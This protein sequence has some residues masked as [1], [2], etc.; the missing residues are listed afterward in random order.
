MS[1][2]EKVIETTPETVEEAPVV[3][4][5]PAAE[6]E[7]AAAN[8][9]TTDEVQAPEAAAAEVSGT[10]A[11]KPKADAARKPARKPRKPVDPAVWDELKAMQESGEILT[12]KINAAV[13]AGV[14]S[15][16][17]GIRGFIPASLLSVKY[18][19]DLTEWVNKT[20][21][22]KVITVEQENKRLVLSGKAVEQERAAAEKAA[23][24]AAVQIG[25]IYD[26]KVERIT[27][28]GAFVGFGDGL[29]GLVH[30]SQ[31]ANHRIETP[32][33]VVKV[34]DTVKVK[35]IG[36]KDG[37]LSLSMKQAVSRDAG[38]A[39]AKERSDRDSSFSY[40]EEGKATTGLAS[41]LANIKID[42]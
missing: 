30:I 28:F 13:N 20:I 34:G 37:K 38:S 17:K 15:Y 24:I 29:S 31:M 16:V 36:N 42:E 21:D 6:P 25:D 32:N 5:A 1:T 35:V 12:V 18:V 22:V 41:L 27:S 3:T 23:K 33:E 7:A 2:D 4:E 9:Q 11:E 39:P 19:E 14:I 26:G 40:K 8:S 10:E